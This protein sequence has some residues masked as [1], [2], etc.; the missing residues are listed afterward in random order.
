VNDAELSALYEREKAETLAA[1]EALLVDADANGWSPEKRQEAVRLAHS[2]KGAA[3]SMGERAVATL[4]RLLEERLVK[5]PEVPTLATASSSA[6]SRDAHPPRVKEGAPEN[7]R[8]WRVTFT[9]TPILRSNPVL[10]EELDRSLQAAGALFPPE[11]REFP[12]GFWEG[13]LTTGD[14]DE[15]VI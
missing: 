5:W 12:S 4:A 2:L 1:I 9:P 3:A 7:E 6:S 13:E 10:Q 11:W 8:R 15:R 14:A